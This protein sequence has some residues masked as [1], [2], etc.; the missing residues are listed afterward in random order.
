MPERLKR[1]NRGMKKINKKGE[2]MTRYAF[3]SHMEDYMKKL[4]TEPK[5]A[6]PDEFLKSFGL[7]GKACLDILLKKNKKNEP[8]SAIMTRREKIKSSKK[9][10]DNSP[11]VVKDVFTIKYSVPR[12]DYNKKMRNA[13]INLFENYRCDNPLLTEDESMPDFSGFQPSAITEDGEGGCGDVAGGATGADS[14]GQ[15]SQP[16]FGQ[17]VRRKLFVTQEQLDYIKEA[18]LNE[19]CPAEVGTMFGDFGFDAPGLDL[20]NDPSLDHRNMMKKSWN[21]GKGEKRIR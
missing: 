20:K 21:N 11:E 17:P 15:Y 10:G 19:D 6:S 12:K 1:Y 13:Y 8:E 16:L 7:D 2:E 9:P 4:L 3:I 5:T 18:M 14:S